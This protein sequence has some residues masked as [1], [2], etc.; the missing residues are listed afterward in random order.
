[1][2]LWPLAINF[3]IIMR[4]YGEFFPR[5]ITIVVGKIIRAVIKQITMIS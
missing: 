3:D 2:A 5:E 4:I 1:M